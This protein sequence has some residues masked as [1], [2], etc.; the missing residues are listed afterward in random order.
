MPATSGDRC[1]TFDESWSVSMWRCVLRR[2]SESEKSEIWDGSHRLVDKLLLGHTVRQE[3]GG[4]GR[5]VIMRT[6]LVGVSAG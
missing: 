1:N 6:T 5:Q 2:L 4:W 3:E